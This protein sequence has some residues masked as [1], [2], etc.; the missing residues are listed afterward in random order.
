MPVQRLGRAKNSNR[1]NESD[2]YVLGTACASSKR[3]RR[4]L[5]AVW[6]G[7]APEGD[8]LISG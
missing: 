4:L 7:Q 5:L 6:D 2:W 3:N 1:L 8:R